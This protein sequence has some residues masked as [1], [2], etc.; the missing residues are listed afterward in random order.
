MGAACTKQGYLLKHGRRPSR[1]KGRLLSATTAPHRPAPERSPGRP[2]APGGAV[3][4]HSPPESTPKM[5]SLHS[6]NRRLASWKRRCFCL[7][8][9]ELFYYYTAEMSNP[10]QPLGVISLKPEPL[11]E[12][13]PPSPPS[14][15]GG[16]GGGGADMRG[17]TV[18]A[19]ADIGLPHLFGLTVH[20]KQRVW[21]LAADTAADR[22][23]WIRVLC[24]AGAQLSTSGAEEPPALPRSAW[25]WAEMSKAVEEAAGKG[26]GSEGGG[27][28][29]GGG[30]SGGGKGDKGGK[31]SEGDEAGSAS[32]EAVATLNGVLWK[33]ASKVHIAQAAVAESGLARDWVTRHFRLI[34]SDGTLAYFQ[35]QGDAASVESRLSAARQPGSLCFASSDGTKSKG[36][37]ARSGGAPAPPGFP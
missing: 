32:D 18:S 5:R 36:C 6:T 1:S 23:E 19:V 9:S 10:F 27:G 34:P 21:D 12:P 16:G 3:S 2:G 24:Q 29:G 30:E 4:S 15:G 31:G 17:A 28:E 20:T 33:R 35:K 13:E 22:D 26:S 14:G 8:A 7:C 11:D 25:A 37:P